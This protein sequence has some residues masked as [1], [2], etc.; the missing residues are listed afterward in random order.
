MMQ[1]VVCYGETIEIG[2]IANRFVEY[3]VTRNENKKRNIKTTHEIKMSNKLDVW[4][5]VKKK[6]MGR[7]YIRMQ[8]A[9][10]L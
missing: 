2:R 5:I 4:K 1:R 6:V 9:K 8:V 3:I 7:S 10:R